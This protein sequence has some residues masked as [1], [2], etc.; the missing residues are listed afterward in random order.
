MGGG[1]GRGEG[2][3]E[4]GC[5]CVCVCVCGGKE[6]EGGRAVRE[7]GRGR[8]EREPAHHSSHEFFN[9]KRLKTD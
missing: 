5:V 1:A 4:G 9:L 8:G 6:R 7:W 3:R 2:G